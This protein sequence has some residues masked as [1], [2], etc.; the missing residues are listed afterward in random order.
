MTDNAAIQ[1][2]KVNYSAGDT[3]ILKN[4]TG[5][6]R[7]GKITTLIGPSGSG[8]TTLFKLCNGLASP[9]NGEI[10]FL[11]K[12]IKRYDP[13]TLRRDVGL[14]LQDATM[15][16]GSVRK[17]LALP[18]ELQRKQ[19]PQD[20]ARE[21]MEVVGLDKELLNRDARELSGGQRQRLSIAR[22]LVNKP[23]VLLL[24]E[25]T[26]SLDPVSKKDVENLIIEMNRTDGT[27]I[28]WITHNI[29]Q[30]RHLGDDTWV[31]MEGKL[32]ESGDSKLLDNPANDLV[33]RFVKGEVE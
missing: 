33:K 18:L 4:I 8:K 12:S 15:V 17:N 29:E 31:M 16:R 3:P 2:N 25:I 28:V 10:H 19:L 24:D 20:R 11:D 13:V 26:S 22:T 1:F 27:T 5:V 32:V 6:F 21:L 30:A 9:D 7:K 23:A 14:A